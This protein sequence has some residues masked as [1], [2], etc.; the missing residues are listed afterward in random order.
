MPVEI[1]AL[2]LENLEVNCQVDCP[3]CT[4]CGA[5]SSGGTGNDL[6]GDPLYELILARFPG[7][8]QALAD[9]SSPQRAAF[10]WLASAANDQRPL[11]QKLLQRYA[12]A[13]L[14]YATEGTAW[15]QS[16]LW[17]S[18]MEECSWFNTEEKGLVC[19]S[20]GRVVEINLQS[21]NLQG[22]IPL[23]ILLLAS[24]L[25]TNAQTVVTFII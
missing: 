25:G 19:N 24:T 3:C 1:C 7:G 6:E 2:G 22:S 15:V 12:L 8:R 20:D 13:S 9:P 11:D 5:G 10:D 17:L 21:N 18:E 23:E 16:S 14:F 4:A